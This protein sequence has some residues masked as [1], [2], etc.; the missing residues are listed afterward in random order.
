MANTERIQKAPEGKYEGKE[1]L[2]MDEAED[3]L[4]VKRSTL[5][6]RITKLAIQV[7]KFDGDRRHFLSIGDVLRI[8]TVIEK[9]WLAG[10]T[11]F[12]TL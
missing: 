6:T 8:E 10:E 12:P 5:Q 1:Y 7:R 9:P 3:Y 11:K 4:G 2:S